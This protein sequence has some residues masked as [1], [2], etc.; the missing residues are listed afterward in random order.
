MCKIPSDMIA[1]TIHKTNNFGDLKITKYH[2]YKTVDV[3]FLTTGY[4]TTSR[5]FAIKSGGVKDR[6]LPSVCG[7]GFIGDGGFKASV[8]RVTT[9]SYQ[10]WVGMIKRCYSDLSL[11]KHA[12]YEG[13]TVC[14]E[15]H[16]FQVFAKWFDD[17]YIVGMALDKDI[18]VDGNK[19]YSP[20]TC[21]FVSQSENN[22]K[23]RAKEYLFIS[24]KGIATKVYNLNEFC[25]KNNLTGANM[26]AVFSG[27]RGSHKGWKKPTGE[28]INDAN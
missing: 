18:L 7:V 4:K 14:D 20:S 12:T 27:R 9:T 15:W 8:K 16:N 22:V 6:I 28:F 11:A 1:G 17:N 26:S 5:A 2:N 24:P 23:A 21:L 25:R 3:E 10:C 19:K 13:C